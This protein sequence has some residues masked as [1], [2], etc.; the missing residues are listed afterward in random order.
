MLASLLARWRGGGATYTHVFALQS[1][2]FLNHDVLQNLVVEDL[3]QLQALLRKVCNHN[4]A[5]QQPA[6]W[7]RRRPPSLLLRF[8]VKEPA[9][10]T[11][12]LKPRTN[13]VNGFPKVS[14]TRDPPR[15]V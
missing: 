13:K 1:L 15:F 12:R 2:H 5:N 11:Q 4:R 14:V 7:R 8:P 10:K 6:P 3:G 9:G